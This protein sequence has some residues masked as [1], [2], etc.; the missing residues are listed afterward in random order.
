MPMKII[1]NF[2]KERYAA[3]MFEFRHEHSQDIAGIRKVHESAF[4]TRAEADLVDALRDIKAHIISLVAVR[5]ARIVG[6][7]LF[8]P[9]TL[10]AE[11][12][13]VTL[14]GLA[15]MAVL[16]QYQRKGIGSKLVEKGLKECRA[17][18]YPAVAVLGHPAYYPR[19]GFVPSIKYNITSEYDV[20]HDVFM[21][22]ELQPGVLAG[23][24]GIAKYHAV[25]ADL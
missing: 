1:D 11:G 12:R 6:H 3:E 19:F 18:S 14:P 23:I 8:S 22:K 15:P 7:I 17:K 13:T 16:A 20:P 24:S 9:V 10:E 25:F 4:E 5:G 21:I 2:D